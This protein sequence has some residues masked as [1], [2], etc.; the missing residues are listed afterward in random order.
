VTNSSTI[1]DLVFSSKDGLGT[2]VYQIRDFESECFQN[3]TLE[4]MNW[5]TSHFT[6]LFNEFVQEQSL[7]QKD[8]L[9]MRLPAQDIF[10]IQSACSAGFY[11]VEGSIEPYLLL[12]NWKP[13]DFRQYIRPIKHADDSTIGYVE[14]IAKSAFRGL[15][16]NIDPNIGNELADKR[17]L[18]W[19][20]NAYYEGQD[21]NVLLKDEEV[22]GFSLL[23]HINGDETIWKLGAVSPRTKICGAGLILYASTLAYCQSRGVKTVIGGI[24]MA[25]VP[26]LNVHSYLGFNFRNPTVVLHY[27]VK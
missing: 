7:K 2:L 18:Q 1:R 23:H 17:Y 16:F 10:S 6:T 27:M 13:N 12:K 20:R 4:I 22:L 24:S 5:K 25:N 21:V 26:A 8:F 15:R 11:F 3:T 14:E 9:Y 19:L